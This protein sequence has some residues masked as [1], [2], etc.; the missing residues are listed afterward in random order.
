[1]QVGGS[2]LFFTMSICMSFHPSV[3]P[4]IVCLQTLSSL[5]FSL[6]FSKVYNLVQLIIM[7]SVMSF[8]GKE[9]PCLLG[10][11]RGFLFSHPSVMLWFLSEGYLISTAY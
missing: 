5:S 10:W 8:I 2:I 4:S 3:C 7:F 9:R 6:F 1:M 11:C